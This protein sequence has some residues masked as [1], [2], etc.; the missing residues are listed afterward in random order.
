MFYLALAV[1][2]V[3]ILDTESRFLETGL[4]PMDYI[5]MA[6]ATWRL[7]RFFAFDVI[8]RFFR[9][10]FW[11]LKKVGRGFELV[12][13][14]TGPRRTLAD[15]LSCPA[16]LG[17]WMGSTVVFFYMLTPLAFIPVVILA[18]AALWQFL[19][20]LGSLVAN[21][22]EYFEKKAKDLD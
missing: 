5:L 19:Q 3:I 17:I 14:A 12:K 9:E 21:S 1:M 6:L 4:Q 20:N 8:T 13:P 10:Q 16:C 15:L 11:D 7:I 18:M 22:S 2:G